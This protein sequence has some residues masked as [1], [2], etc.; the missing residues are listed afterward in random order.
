LRIGVKTHVSAIPIPLV[1]V[2]PVALLLCFSSNTQTPLKSFASDDYE[3]STYAGYDVMCCVLDEP[4]VGNSEGSLLLQ[5]PTPFAMS[6][7]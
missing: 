3:L 1:Y 5:I 6:I 2:V 7:C 4:K